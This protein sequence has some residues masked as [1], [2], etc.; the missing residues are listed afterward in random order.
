MRWSVGGVGGSVMRVILAVTERW[1][2]PTMMR[3]DKGV[4]SYHLCVSLTY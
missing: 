3:R 2:E 1:G 4:I